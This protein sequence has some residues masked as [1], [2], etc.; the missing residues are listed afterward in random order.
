M[1]INTHAV[2]LEER[3]AGASY[4]LVQTMQEA[5]QW[6]ITL[7]NMGGTFR[8]TQ[9]PRAWTITWEPTEMLPGSTRVRK[10]LCMFVFLLLMC[11]Q[12]GYGVQRKWL[13]VLRPELEVMD[14]IVS[15]SIVKPLVCR[16]KACP[17]NVV[18]P[19]LQMVE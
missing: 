8:V 11:L 16:L 14:V 13:L 4:A 12:P 17:Q 9:G 15:A 5:N 2:L 1:S 18:Q 3:S 6:E 19:V 10:S 7:V